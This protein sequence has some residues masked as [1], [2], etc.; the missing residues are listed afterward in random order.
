MP[1]LVVPAVATTATTGSPPRLSSAAFSAAPVKRWFSVGTTNG[2][3][4]RMRQALA[5]EE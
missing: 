3:T 4:S 5:T 1:A 2:S